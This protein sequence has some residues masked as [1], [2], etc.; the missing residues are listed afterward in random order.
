MTQPW[1]PGC[2]PGGQVAVLVHPLTCSMDSRGPG[3]N[4]SNPQ[5]WQACFAMPTVAKEI[6]EGPRGAL[7]EL[8]CC[9]MLSGAAS[10][11]KL[12]ATHFNFLWPLEE[13]ASA[14]TAAEVGFP[15]RVRAGFPKSCWKMT[16][17]SSGQQGL[18]LTLCVCV[19]V[20]MN[21]C[22]LCM[23]A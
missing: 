10:R 19:S 7:W 5:M 12:N 6:T 2:C 11:Q 13:A 22:V 15:L 8:V 4:S 20:C 16:R 18:S 9:E 17:F 3:W 1:L 23:H 14:F 21:V